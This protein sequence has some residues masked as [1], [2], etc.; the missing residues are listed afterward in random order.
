MIKASSSS[1]ALKKINERR[2][3]TMTSIAA[4]AIED[5]I[6]N[7]DLV[8]GDRINESYLADQLGI[9]RGPIREA[10]RS[11]EQ[12]GLLSNKT[13]RGMYVREMSLDEARELYEL[14]GAIAALVGE[15][16][17]KRGKDKEISALVDLVDRM[18]QAANAS[19]AP[20]YYKLNL[21]FH[22]ALVEAS[23][24]RTLAVT[25]HRIVNQLHLLRRRGLVQEGNL[26]ISN[27]E[28]RAI[29]DALVARDSEAAAAAMKSH[30]TNG[31][32]RLLASI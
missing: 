15:L 20:S 27:Q 9:S 24:N 10:C 14:R 13:N 25:Y 31:L 19:D 30:V 4:E 16:I 26:E 6:V 12:A 2:S 29:T 18:Q 5:M 23:G 7:G 8:A 11:L 17:V 21:Q 3:R 22:D 28:H 32:S 1:S